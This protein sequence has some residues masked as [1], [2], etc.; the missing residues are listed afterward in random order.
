MRQAGFQ[1]QLPFKKKGE[2]VSEMSVFNGSYFGIVG[3]R[4][5]NTDKDW[6]TMEL[7]WKSLM[8]QG[9]VMPNDRLVS[10]GCKEGGDRFAE[11][12]ARQCG[13]PLLIFYPN[14]NALDTKLLKVNPRAAWAKINYARNTLVAL[15]S[16]NLIAMVAEDR[17]GGTEDTIQKF[18]RK[19]YG[20]YSKVYEE[21]AIR[22]GRLY[23]T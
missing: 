15:T 13:I 22:R 23:L 10:G 4:R 6:D 12:I 1:A 19:L 14:Q 21:Q 2:R 9:I 18:V 8:S 5:R 7:L 3:S 20:K 11:M 17:K 16:D